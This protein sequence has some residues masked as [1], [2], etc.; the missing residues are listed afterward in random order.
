MTLSHWVRAVLR[1]AFSALLLLGIAVQPV[2]GQG[3]SV[4]NQII[5]LVAAGKIARAEALLEQ[6]NPSALDR[7]FFRGR[8]LK[9]NGQFTAAAAVFR[10]ILEDDPNYL[11]ARRELAHTL[12]LDQK[13][14]A[15][16]QQERPFSIG[17]RFALLP[18]TNVNRGTFNTIFDPG[19]PGIPPSRINSQ[20]ESGVG[21]L[22][23]VSAVHRWA[24]SNNNRLIFD[25]DLT[26]QAYDNEIHNTATLS[27]GATF[28]R[29]F[30]AYQ[31]SVGAYPRS[32]WREDD[33]DYEA[34]GNLLTWDRRLA[35]STSLFFDLRR[36]ERAYINSDTLDGPFSAGR[37]GLTYAMRS[38]LTLIAGLESEASRPDATFQHYDGHAVFGQAVKQ[39]ENGFVT[40]LRV[41][42]GHRHYG[43]DFPLTFETRQDDF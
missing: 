15:A 34:V 10:G 39:W 12:L 13:F 11:D 26:G 35:P 42:L 18:S 31:W 40:G 6:T 21:L 24:L 5:D 23:G 1:P 2:S 43:G 29:S 4:Q 41:E 25:V 37:V 14:A 8:V 17:V 28:Q 3:A 30:E 36:E 27:F 32:T 9:A 33:D 7:A 16:S 20:A 22:L 38:D 19:N